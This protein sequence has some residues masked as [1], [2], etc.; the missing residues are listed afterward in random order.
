MKTGMSVLLLMIFLAILALPYTESAF[1]QDDPAASAGETLDSEDSETPD[2]SGSTPGNVANKELELPKLKHHIVFDPS[3]YEMLAN[4][5][6]GHNQTIAILKFPDKR[7]GRKG[8]VIG[9]LYDMVYHTPQVNLYS[10]QPVPLAIMGVME[11]LFKANGFQVKQFPSVSEPSEI[12]DGTFVVTGQINKFWVKVFHSMEAWVDIDVK[13]IDRKLAKTIW[14]G[15]IQS[16]QVKAPN[17]SAGKIFLGVLG[18]KKDLAP[19]LDETLG[20]AI[21]K[22]WTE[23]G[24]RNALAGNI[25]RPAVKKAKRATPKRVVQKKPDLDRGDLVLAQNSSD[26]KQTIERVK[27]AKN[28]A[29]PKKPQLDMDDLLE[30]IREKQKSNKR[31]KEALVQQVRELREDLSKYKKIVTA[32]VDETIE[33]AAWELLRKKYPEW[34][35][36]VNTGDTASLVNN[37][38]AK[39]TDGTLRK[40]IEPYGG[41]TEKKRLTS[42]RKTFPRQTKEIARDGRFIAYSNGTVLD[43]KTNLM[44]AAKDDGRGL[45]EH[46]VDDYVVNYRGGGH[47]DWR[48]PTIDELTTIY[49]PEKLNR[50]DFRVTGLIAVRGE[51]VWVKAGKSYLKALSFLTGSQSTYVEGEDGFGNDPMFGRSLASHLLPVR[52]GK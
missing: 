52:G 30:K 32:K 9:G 45:M 46:K 23:Q 26:K 12:D 33:L 41:L 34:T 4:K 22:S 38:L 49:D 11:T 6:I 7:E 29:K 35:Y 47:T 48:M 27:Q 40:I 25:K 20:N 1:A 39:D 24:M 36:N 42:V 31:V 16:T 18:D 17:V 28:P 37:A 10:E 2:T 3:K 14:S 5:E 15:K 21:S 50:Y 43:T 51:W 8:M 44:W 19:F 13:I